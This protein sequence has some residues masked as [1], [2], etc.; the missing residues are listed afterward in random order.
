[1]KLKIEYITEPIQA[2]GKLDVI[3]FTEIKP[4][5]LYI[6]DK[7]VP[8]AL[9]DIIMLGLNVASEQYFDMIDRLREEDILE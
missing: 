3:D 1:M 4:P 9:A 6:D 7:L 8:Q 5:E 2:L